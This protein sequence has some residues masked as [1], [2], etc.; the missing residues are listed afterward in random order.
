[1]ESAPGPEA[2]I[3]GKR[4]LYFG[5]TSYLGLASHPEVIEAGCA[6]LR[7]YGVHTATSRARF[8]TNP[9]VLEVERLS[10]RYFG[11][12]DAFYFGSG[13]MANHIM[14]SALAAEADAVLVNEAS[15]F[16][17]L[18]AAQLAGL[19]VQ[20]FHD[21]HDLARLAKSVRRPLIMADA[22]GPSTGAP[23]PVRDYLTALEGCERAMLL[24]DD[25]HGVGVLGPNGRGLL[26]ELGLWERVNIGIAERGA[27]FFVC[28]T[29]AKALGG[30][31][32]VIPGSLAF[33]S[34]TRTSSHYFDGASAPAS[35]VAG[36]TAK[37]LE[38]VMREPEL[39]QT[40]RRNIEL[41]R[42]G[43]RD[44]GLALPESAAANLGVT[45]GGAD[46]MTRIHE[47]LKERGI[48]LPYVRAYAGLPKDGALRFAVFATHTEDHIRQL[49]SELK[50]LL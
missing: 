4:Y 32:G 34:R 12:E 39:R 24:L 11:T 20:T 40:L 33:V 47:G 25:A 2:V 35:P 38:I 27:S 9:P 22:I 19:P 31:G 3:D 18:E 15:H 36:A 6:A 21:A 10:A 23:A 26:D 30:F 41:L 28:A 44:L 37:A 1:M 7:Q 5:G 49:L 16:C 50:T 48:M 14:V 43:L 46:T 13:Y 29:L 42:A 17:V 45:V 8:G